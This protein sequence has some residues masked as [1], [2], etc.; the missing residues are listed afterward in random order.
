MERPPKPSRH[1]QSF[2]DGVRVHV[3][4]NLEPLLH[5]NTSVADHE[6]WRFPRPSCG[7]AFATFLMGNR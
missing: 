7:A 2:K 5:A 6:K 4:N 1:G 3:L